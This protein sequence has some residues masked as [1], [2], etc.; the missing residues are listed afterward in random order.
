MTSTM[1]KR[2]RPS[3]LWNT[4]RRQTAGNMTCIIAAAWQA[5]AN[6]TPGH[7]SLVY[8]VQITNLGADFFYEVFSKWLF[9][10]YISLSLQ[11]LSPL[12]P[13]LMALLQLS[14][15]QTGYR[16]MSLPA[17]FKYI[18]DWFLCTLEKKTGIFPRSGET[19]HLPDTLRAYFWDGGSGCWWRS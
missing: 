11:S 16:N 1:S 14:L 6:A 3:D 18:L 5:R 4:Q 17:V 7:A 9:D 2:V 19:Y 8:R 12:E 13:L 10:H 15:R